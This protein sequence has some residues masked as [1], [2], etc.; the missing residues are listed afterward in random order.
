MDLM[1]NGYSALL[2]SAM[3]VLLVGGAAAC[4]TELA[5]PEPAPPRVLREH[6]DRIKPGRKLQL[7]GVS[8]QLRSNTVHIV[9][10]EPFALTLLDD[11]WL[12]V[13][14]PNVEMRQG[15]PYIRGRGNERY[16]FLRC[17]T[18]RSVPAGARIQFS[19]DECVPTTYEPG[20]GARLTGFSLV[21]R[22][23]YLESGIEPAQVIVRNQK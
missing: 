7:R 23:G 9:N 19:Y 17:A 6:E 10:N 8:L 13:L 12:R 5:W 14:A 3:S 15:G 21:A 11:V 4:H 1:C 18:A 22:E 20:P 2:A 16:V